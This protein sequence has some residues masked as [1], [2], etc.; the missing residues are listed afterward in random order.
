[1]NWS[2]TFKITLFTITLTLGCRSYLTQQPVPAENPRPLNEGLFSEH[3]RTTE[4]RSPEEEKAGF[5]LPDGFQIDLFASE[6]EIGKPLN[7][8]FDAKGRLW[9][10]QSV[11]Y[12]FAAQ[13]GQGRDRLTILEDKDHNG[14]ADTFTTV[15]DTLN[16]PIGVLPRHNGA[17]AF[18]IPNVYRF[19]DQNGDGRVEQSQVLLGPFGYQ[20]TH[21]MVNNL[22]QGFDGWIYACHGFT[23]ESRVAGTD[24]D[25]LKI[26][27]GNTFRF[28]P[29][30]SRAEAH[31]FGRVNPFGMAFDAWGYL[32]SAD[33][34]TSPI[35]QLIAGGD[36]PTFGKVESGIG[37]PPA[38][39]PM[40]DEATALAGLTLPT[41]DNLPVPYRQSFYVGDVVKSRIYRNS[42]T[43][44]GSTPVAKREADFLQSEDPWFRPVDIVEGPDG[45]LYVADFYNRII[46]H[47][48]VPLN[49]PERDHLRGRIWRITYKGKTDPAGHTDWTRA[50]L[51]EL[52]NALSRGNLPLRL[53]VADQLVNRIGKSAIEPLTQLLAHRGRETTPYVHALWML[54]QLNTIS[55]AQ[56]T[57]ALAHPADLVRTHAVRLLNERGTPTGAYQQRLLTLLRDTS[58][59]VRRA[60]AEALTS[61]PQ[62][63]TVR[64]LLDALAGTSADDTHLVYTLKLSLQTLLRQ[65][66]L[67]ETVARANWDEARQ[68]ALATILTGVR[69]SY[70]AEFLFQRFRLV[71]TPQDKDI[72]LVQHLARYLPASQLNPLIQAVREKFAQHV[73]RQYQ[74]FRFIQGGLQQRGLPESDALRRW[75]SQLASTL[76]AQPLPAWTATLT[77]GPSAGEIPI[78][79]FRAPAEVKQPGGANFIGLVRSSLRGTIQSPTFAA[80]ARLRF[81]VLHQNEKKAGASPHVVQ[82][83]LSDDTTRLVA[84]QVL[85][86]SDGLQA[87]AM[88]WDLTAWQGRKVFLEIRKEAPGGVLQVGL[89]DSTVLLMPTVSPLEVG[90]QLRFAVENAGTY[91]ISSLAP[92]VRNLLVAASTPEFIRTAAAKALLQMDSQAYLP[93]LGGMLQDNGQPLSF[94]RGVINVLGEF[95]RPEITSL[96]QQELTRSAPETQTDLVKALAASSSGKRLIVQWVRAGLLPTRMLVQPGIGDKLLLD[97]DKALRREYAELT[98]NLGPVD[99]QRDALIDERLSNYLVT[100]QGLDRGKSAFVQHCAACHQIRKEGGSIGPQLDGVGNWG[101]RAL[102]TKILDPNRNISEAFRNY[103]I[104]LKNGTVRTGLFRREEGQALVYASVGGEEFL[105]R[106]ADIA[107]VQASKYTLMPD[108]FSQT[109]PADQFNDLLTYLLSIR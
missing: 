99:P 53:T 63:E 79:L 3:V 40:E 21:G 6:P 103:T 80:P 20:D 84:R 29:D 14:R 24:R 5:I 107:E 95:S 66:A 9:V 8:A 78:S 10:T 96:L 25:S 15:A 71:A 22:T 59:H 11:E 90:H 93:L 4:P 60:A 68:A 43:W 69:E 62:L 102:A 38:M 100:A 56:L 46:G 76:V 101:A 94:R 72:A 28:R 105:V 31:T 64:A 33:C 1:M 70:A 52:I 73:Q 88:N 45:A 50:T 75:G 83:R 74:V 58:P 32:Y 91:R 82:V 16:I 104:K 57:R 30:G 97:S 61:Y 77:D 34:H 87:S 92:K 47:Y 65:P 55:D 51:Q 36:Y 44:Q 19:T 106:K 37:F 26:V 17:I 13:P 48:E 86:Q 89:L 41:G 54:H 18:S 49:N 67:G 108:Y 81:T 39:K 109:L 35:Y 42:F 23:N 27:S 85:P 7:M 98:I 12:P 2:S